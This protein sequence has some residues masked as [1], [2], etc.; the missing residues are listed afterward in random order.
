MLII[1]FNGNAAVREIPDKID[2][3]SSP[4][5]LYEV[6]KHAYR[7]SIKPRMRTIIREFYTLMSHFNPLHHELM[8]IKYHLDRAKKQTLRVSTSCEKERTE[9]CNL[10]LKKLY[11]DLSLLDKSILQAQQKLLQ[12]ISVPQIE[13]PR[14]RRRS[15]KYLK[16]KALERKALRESIQT[17]LTNTHFFDEI[18]I[19]S[20][21]CINEVERSLISLTPSFENIQSNALL[22]TTYLEQLEI[23][24]SILLVEYSFEKYRTDIRTLWTHYINPLR[25]MAFKHNNRKHLINNLEYLS[26]IINDFRM[27]MTKG[28]IKIPTKAQGL[29]NNM[30]SRWN[31]ILRVIIHQ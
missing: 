9:N 24:W 13:E 3:Q 2:T 20:Y 18:G 11:N 5:Q 4:P 26:F 25:Q 22:L 27:K 7:R 10:I 8:Q 30:H 17:L 6:S 31:W 16:E 23:L 14:T 1:V 12:Q 28:T 19:L 15:K 29:L 21:K